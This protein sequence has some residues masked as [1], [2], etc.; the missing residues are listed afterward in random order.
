MSVPRC[1]G[2]DKKGPA[3]DSG[4]AFRVVP[5]VLGGF[6]HPVADPAG[7]TLLLQLLQ[8]LAHRGL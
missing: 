5:R 7:P 1:M 3:R 4:G 8:R 6:P 2:L